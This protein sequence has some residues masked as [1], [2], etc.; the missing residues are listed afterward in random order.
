MDPRF[1]FCWVRNKKNLA[2]MRNKRAFWK[3][4]ADRC[5]THATHTITAFVPDKRDTCDD[6][7]T[8]LVSLLTEGILFLLLSPD[9]RKVWNVLAWGQIPLKR[10]LPH[11]RANGLEATNGYV[12]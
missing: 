8:R 4:L 12:R 2:F 7:D 9:L 1:Q 6:T 10:K 5:E 3:N 11:I